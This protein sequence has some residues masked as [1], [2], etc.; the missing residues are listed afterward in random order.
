MMKA[1]EEWKRDVEQ[2]RDYYIERYAREEYDDEPY[3]ESAEDKRAWLLR[4][5]EEKLQLKVRRTVSA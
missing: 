2:R 3:W 5:L 1:Q 4:L